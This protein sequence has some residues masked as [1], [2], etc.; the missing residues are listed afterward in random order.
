SWVRDAVTLNALT[1]GVNVIYALAGTFD[2]TTAH[3]PVE[4]VNEDGIEMVDLTQ[5]AE[6]GP[7]D[8][9]ETVTANLHSAWGI[10]GDASVSLID[11]TTYAILNGGTVL[12]FNPDGT[13][14]VLNADGT[15]L[16]EAQMKIHAENATFH[17]ALAGSASFQWGTGT[18]AASGGIAG[19]FAFL[20]DSADTL[21]LAGL[22]K[23]DFYSGLKS[24]FTVSPT[25]NTLD[26]S[27]EKTGETVLL[28]IG[29]AGAFTNSR[30]E[31]P[32][33]GSAGYAMIGD[34]TRAEIAGTEIL[35]GNAD[36]SLTEEEQTE[37]Q[38]L[39]AVLVSAKNRADI[40]NLA[41][42]VSISGTVGF[43]GAAAVS[44]IEQD[45]SALLK[46]VSLSADSLTLRTEDS[47]LIVHSALGT[48]IASPSS[49]IVLFSG[50][51]AIGVLSG[52]SQAGM[53]ADAAD[54]LSSVVDLTG[55]LSI[56]TANTIRTSEEKN[57]T[58]QS[59]A[60]EDFMPDEVNE[61][62][63]E[64]EEKEI[65]VGDD[66][67]TVPVTEGS[68]TGENGE[69]GDPMYRTVR[70]DVDS[71][72]AKIVS[73]AVDA[74]VGK[75]A[76]GSAMS[77]NSISTTHESILKNVQVRLG[78]DANVTAGTDGGIYAFNIGGS[79]GTAGAGGL[80]AGVN[81]ISQNTFVSLENM[82]LQNV[83][84]A[85]HA[86]ETVQD[87]FLAEN[88][89]QIVSTALDVRVSTECAAANFLAAYNQTGN[90]TLVQMKNADILNEFGGIRVRGV[91]D[92]DII[93][94]MVQTGIAA[95]AGVSANV[96]INSIGGVKLKDSEEMETQIQT[97]LDGT[98]GISSDRAWNHE[99]GIRISDGS[100]LSAAFG[101]LDLNA[102]T[103]GQLVSIAV[104]AAGGGTAAVGVSGSYANIGSATVVDVSDSRLET[105]D[106]VFLTVEEACALA[107]ARSVQNGVTLTEVQKTALKNYFTQYFA[108][109]PMHSG[110]YL[111]PTASVNGGNLSI[112]N[113]DRSLL[114]NVLLGGSGAGAA[115]V[116]VNCGVSDIQQAI[117]TRF[118]NSSLIAGNQI[119]SLTAGNGDFVTVGGNAS[120]G[121][122]G[123]GVGVNFNYSEYAS[124]LKQQIENSRL[125]SG[126]GSISLQTVSDRYLFVLSA[127]GA[128]SGMVGVDANVGLNFLSNEVSV[129]VSEGAAIH[130]GGDVLLEARSKDSIFNLTPTLAL[131]IMGGGVG[132]NTTVTDISTQTFVDVLSPKDGI[133]TSLSGLDLY[134]QADPLTLSVWD[135]E[136]NSQ[137][138]TVNGVGIYALS[139]Q[140]VQ[141]LGIAAAGGLYFGAAGSASV[142]LNEAQT[143]ARMFG[144]SVGLSDFSEYFDAPIYL[145]VEIGGDADG[146]YSFE[147]VNSSPKPN[148]TQKALFRTDG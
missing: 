99:A 115:G 106:Y 130:A 71:D 123:A 64:W 45:T 51:A 43:G 81:L 134:R 125:L 116:L 138:V 50:A 38:K 18:G 24:G 87:S 52:T 90:R 60:L 146:K 120:I 73:F 66:L 34:S 89:A 105:N 117:Q 20:T 111:V 126:F 35:T 21:A 7:T 108:G 59:L 139:D 28:S 148:L 46:N 98:Y 103:D 83:R 93:A 47:G 8:G 14:S 30:A 69:S 114:V 77:V 104:T 131:G 78:G 67:S 68:T 112:Q 10:A 40:I 141:S 74:S 143:R 26:V 129:T 17:H 9:G 133:S 56:Q 32:I 41:G 70:V 5:E 57:A 61:E 72:P 137:D 95:T 119:T 92:S 101:N 27:A 23:L 147:E 15:L 136:G 127:S 11:E 96:S 128:G 65:Y 124:V 94:I 22:E 4:E 107:E 13:G 135:S 140:K 142:I 44:V 31:I 29:A 80:S 54:P 97:L 49:G 76:L 12:H 1:S 33:A 42:G 55:D 118:W 63:E 6:N 62:L 3:L 58:A 25:K 19:S 144:A 75:I 16:G 53:T 2:N 84:P 79:V 121:L 132:A 109:L 39:T 102:K 91:A 36:V 86:F 85:G 110:K 88:R 145:P 113:E 122:E 100:L 37:L 82:T 48:A